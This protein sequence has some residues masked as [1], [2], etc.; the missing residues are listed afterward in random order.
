MAAFSF[1]IAILS[2]FGFGF[3]RFFHA[4]I[5]LFVVLKYRASLAPFG[6]FGKYLLFLFA[7]EI[8][9]ENG[10]RREQEAYSGYEGNKG[11]YASL[12]ALGLR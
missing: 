2:V 12:G 4:N 10:Y 9:E 7:A 1:C 8:V 6:K 3:G 5:E 11:E